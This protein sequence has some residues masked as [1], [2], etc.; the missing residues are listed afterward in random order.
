[1]SETILLEVSAQLQNG[2]RAFKS[3]YDKDGRKYL[4]TCIVRD[5]GRGYRCKGWFWALAKIAVCLR[6]FLTPR[7]GLDSIA[8]YYDLFSAIEGICDVGIF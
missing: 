2:G 8:E 5:V 4:F 3:Q 1:M 7:S 6:L